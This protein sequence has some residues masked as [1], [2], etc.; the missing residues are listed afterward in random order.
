MH[1]NAGNCIAFVKNVIWGGP[2]PPPSIEWGYFG[3]NKK[4]LQ[5][6]TIFHRTTYIYIYLKNFEISLRTKVGYPGKCLC[7][8]ACNSGNV[9]RSLFAALCF[10]CI[11]SLKGSA[12]ISHLKS[13]GWTLKLKPVLHESNYCY[14]SASKWLIEPT[15]ICN[16]QVDT[17]TC[18][19]KCPV[20]MPP[21]WQP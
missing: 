10:L 6:T 14:N 19:W 16:S 3:L 9:A 8:S 18:C 13:K 7:N 15:G 1:Q 17:E 4:P 5:Y 2:R 11:S 12:E 21:D 20:H